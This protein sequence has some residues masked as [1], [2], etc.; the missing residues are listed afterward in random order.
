METLPTKQNTVP[1]QTDSEIER[2]AITKSGV[3]Y[4]DLIMAL[5]KK[6]VNEDS[7]EADALA[8]RIDASL[9]EVDA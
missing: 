6:I 4:Q 7:V 8:Q 5:W 3:T 9:A 1:G 2:D